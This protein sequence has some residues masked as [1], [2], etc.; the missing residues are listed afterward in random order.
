MENIK[1]ILP[2]VHEDLII[3]A[4]DNAL[5][6]QVCIT[7]VSGEEITGN[8]VRHNKTSVYIEVPQN[9]DPEEL[10]LAIGVYGKAYVEK[11]LTKPTTIIVLPVDEIQTVTH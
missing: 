4:L 2:R 11:Y 3:K 1:D 7:M 6:K 8:V 9:Y 5:G 10:E